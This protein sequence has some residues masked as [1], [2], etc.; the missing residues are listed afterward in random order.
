MAVL[1]NQ[2]C[3]LCIQVKKW[4]NPSSVGCSYWGSKTRTQSDQDS[5]FRILAN[6]PFD[7][8]NMMF[9][10]NFNVK[11]QIKIKNR[12]LELIQ[13]AEHKYIPICIC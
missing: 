7:E 3:L 8:V 4:C 2:M 11:C 1:C 12:Q 9:L 5:L 13:N 6:A 10:H